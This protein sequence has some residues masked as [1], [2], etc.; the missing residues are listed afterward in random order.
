MNIM[1]SMPTSE[2]PQWMVFSVADCGLIINSRGYEKVHP[3][4]EAQVCEQT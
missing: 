2:G 1:L 3:L 4:D